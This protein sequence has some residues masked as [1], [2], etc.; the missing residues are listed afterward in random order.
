MC[1]H[2]NGKITN[3]N[4]L[5]EIITDPTSVTYFCPHCKKSIAKNYKELRKII[6]RRRRLIE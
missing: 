1:P 6:R 3:S 4:F 5:F 2:C